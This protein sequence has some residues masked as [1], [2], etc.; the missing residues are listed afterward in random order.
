MSAI[1]VA[2][3]NQK[4][5]W[6][7]PPLRTLNDAV[8]LKDL[9]EKNYDKFLVEEGIQLQPGERVEIKIEDSE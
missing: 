8:F 6:Q 3:S 1:V 9:L 2:V 7:T 4:T 5:V